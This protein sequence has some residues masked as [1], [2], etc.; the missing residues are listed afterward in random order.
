[1]SYLEKKENMSKVTKK[2]IDDYNSMSNS[3]FASKYNCTKLVYRKRVMMYGDPYM[4]SPL[5][6]VGKILSKLM[7][8]GEV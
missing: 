4:N 1:M 7:R 5:A 3:E 8:T 6:K 2:V